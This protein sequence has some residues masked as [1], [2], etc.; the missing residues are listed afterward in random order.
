LALTSPTSGDRSV[1][2]VRSWTEAPEFVFVFIYLLLSTYKLVVRKFYLVRV[3]HVKNC[4]S[5]G[6][7]SDDVELVSGGGIVFS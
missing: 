4:G 6:K 7:F 1:G 3:F 2:I 5:L